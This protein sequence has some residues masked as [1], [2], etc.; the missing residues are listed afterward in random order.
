MAFLERIDTELKAALKGRKD[1]RLNI[2][3]MLKSDLQY[4]EKELGRALTEEDIIVVLSSA[5]KKRTEAIDEYVKGG[6]EDLAEAERAEFEVIKEFLPR[7]LSP[8]ELEHLI[9]SAISETGASS[10]SGL[11]A[12]MKVL[13]P[14]VRGRADGKA[15][16]VAVRDKLM[17]K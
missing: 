1:S 16:N 2:L 3:R 9:D 10:I 14:K 11:G 12:V 15:V 7:Q 8:E 4:K 13:M 6:R 5:A 17:N